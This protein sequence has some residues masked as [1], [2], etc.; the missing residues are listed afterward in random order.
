MNQTIEIK[1]AKQAEV[2][3]TW[4]QIKERPGVYAAD[5]EGA[6]DDYRF[7]VLKSNSPKNSGILFVY[8]KANRVEIANPN[9]FEYFDGFRFYEVPEKITLTFGN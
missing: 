2:K 9:A 6:P 4:E 7:V 1:G 8:P 5:A 3:Y